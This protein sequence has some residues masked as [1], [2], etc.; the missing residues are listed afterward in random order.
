MLHHLS[1]DCPGVRD[2]I[3]FSKRV[4]NSW[5]ALDAEN[6][7]HMI[8]IGA[9]N[10]A[11]RMIRIPRLFTSGANHNGGIRQMVASLAG[12]RPFRFH[13]GY[14]STEGEERHRALIFP[15]KY[16]N[17]PRARGRIVQTNNCADLTMA[18]F[19]LPTEHGARRELSYEVVPGVN[20]A[21]QSTIVT[22][23]LNP[24]LPGTPRQHRL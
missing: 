8:E 22:R 21:G 23:A 4:H 14:G 19:T 24:S 2:E 13:D 1:E 6:G 5:R 12:L 16:T 15:P 17:S 18:S 11:C 9:H 10:D 3:M 20:R 7:R